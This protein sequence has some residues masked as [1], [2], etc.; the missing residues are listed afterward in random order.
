MRIKE[1]ETRLTLQE[2]E[3]DD[4]CI[5][6]FRRVMNPVVPPAVINFLVEL[7][8]PLKMEAAGSSEVF[9]LN[10]YDKR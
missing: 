1:Q 2:H 10:T 4:G 6:V 7:T 8:V 9:V 3:D 5:D